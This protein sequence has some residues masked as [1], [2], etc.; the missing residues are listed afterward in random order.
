VLAGGRRRRAVIRRVECT[1]QVPTYYPALDSP[2]LASWAGIR[3]TE[4]RWPG[5]LIGNGA[6]IAVA[7]SFAYPSLLGVARGQ[8]VDHPLSAAASSL[9][10]DLQTTNFEFVL[11]S[12]KLAGRVATAVGTDAAPFGPLYEQVQQAL[13]DAVGHVHVPW[14]VVADQ[15]LP[16]IRAELRN[17]NRVFSTNYDLLA[18]WAIMREGDPNDF[19]DFFWGGG[20]RFDPADTEVTADAT[21]VH[22]LHGGVHLRR[23]RDGGTRKQTAQGQNLLTQ[24][25]TDWAGD[26]TPLLVSEGTSE[27]KM[28]SISRSDYLSFAYSSLA[29]HE[30][31]LVVF[32]HGFGE[33][34]DHLL[35]AINTWRSTPGSNRQVAISLRGQLTETERRQEKA[36]LAQRLPEADL[37]FYDADSHPLGQPNVRPRIFGQD[38]A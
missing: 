7:S 19:R 23:A 5:L 29:R 2:D 8:A 24:F 13:F 32:G 14:E 9:F 30:G 26:E 37:W 28:R 25:S 4:V 36:R 33:Q 1:G 27:D 35:R 38:L 21:L 12:L 6:S 22:Y 15:S 20:G 34:D 18:Y 17:Y 11:A 10:D 16:R 3:Q 31:N